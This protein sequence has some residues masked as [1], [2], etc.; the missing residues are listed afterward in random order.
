MTYS[1]NGIA[2]LETTSAPAGAVPHPLIA[3]PNIT[4]VNVQNRASEE[5]A[6]VRKELDSVTPHRVPQVTAF[7]MRWLKAAIG[8]EGVNKIRGFRDSPD[9]CL[10]LRGLD[11]I[12]YVPTPRNGFLPETDCVLDFD[13][14]HFGMLGLMGIDPFAVDYENEGKL[15]RN[16]LPVEAAAGIASSWGADIEFSWHTDNPNW[17]FQLG[18]ENSAS[19]VPRFL[20]FT[21]IRN[22]EKVSTDVTSVDRVLAA[23][24]GWAVAELRRPVFLFEAPASNEGSGGNLNKLPIIE[25][26]D[27]QN[28]LRFDENIVTATDRRSRASLEILSSCLRAAIGSEVVLTPGDFFIFKN[29]RVLHRRRAFVPAQGGDARWLRRVYGS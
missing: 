28:L 7:G 6:Q 4:L 16:V 8:D 10:Q 14:L 29:S 26:Q 17:N 13:I 19:C 25:V 20:S 3:E 2:H 12:T 11:L 23:L 18:K 9:E 1:T 22:N 15:V 21:A 24:P 5:L 27:G